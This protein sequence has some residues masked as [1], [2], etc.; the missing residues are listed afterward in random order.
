MSTVKPEMVRVWAVNADSADILDPDLDTP[1][2]GKEDAGPGKV[3]KG[4]DAD[5]V[6]PQ[7]WFN[8]EQNRQG[9]F[10]NH[11]NIEGIPVWDEN[12]KYVENSY[13]KDPTDGRIYRSL[14]GTEL[15]PN[16]GNQPS[17]NLDKWKKQIETELEVVVTPTNTAPPGGSEVVTLTPLLESSAFRTIINVPHGASEYR[18]ARDSAM[19]DLVA[20]SGAL[21]AVEQ[22]LVTPALAA[23]DDYFWDVRYQNLDGTW[24][25]RSTST[26]FNIPES[27]VQVP[28]NLL[29]T[30]LD[31]SQTDTVILNSDAF[32]STP[33]SV[34][35][36]SQWQITT[37][38][39]FVTI[40]FDSGEDLI[41]LLSFTQAG[42]ELNL[43]TYYWRVRYKSDTLGWSSFSAPFSF[44]TVNEAVQK[45]TNLTPTNGTT[46]VGSSVQLTGDSFTSIPGGAQVHT[47]SQWQ[48]G[49]SDFSVIYFDSGTDAVNL[50]TI[51]A[52]GYPEGTTTAYW[53]VR[54]QGDITGFSEWSTPFTF[55]TVAVF[56]DWLNWDGLSDGVFV[57]VAGQASISSSKRPV[58]VCDIG[59]GKQLVCYQLNGSTS[60]SATVMTTTG[61]VTVTGGSDSAV[62]ADVDEVNCVGI[63]TDRAVVMTKDDTSDDLR[64]A[65]IDITG[66][67]P[68][69]GADVIAASGAGGAS[70]S[71]SSIVKLDSG[72][73]AL[74]YRE[75]GGDL[76]CNVID[77]SGATPVAQTPDVFV[78]THGLTSQ[79]A[80]LLEADKIVCLARNTTTDTLLTIV[81]NF[82]GNTTTFAA[83]SNV[84]STS[85]PGS[86]DMRIARTGPS[87]FAY[88]AQDGGSMEITKA[89]Y[90]GG[91]VITTGDVA[92]TTAGA[93]DAGQIQLLSPVD[94]QLLVLTGQINPSD[95]AFV[96][97]IDPVTPVFKTTVNYGQSEMDWGQSVAMA[98]IDDTRVALVLNANNTGTLKMK[99]LNG[100]P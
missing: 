35:T 72:R 54:Y 76:I 47:A 18:V 16:V 19:T 46:E 67:T 94:D 44:T 39:N 91:D 83:S 75:V 5:N 59:G 32:L 52:T 38:V 92:S 30:D 87:A 2:P 81:C 84:K 13:S 82:S 40:D 43:T 33:P 97:P 56:A 55:V 36:A 28:T 15:D 60:V 79:S 7:T 26:G 6:P 20:L 49:N 73:V 48:V 42:I 70:T 17:L 29:P 99:I 63:D 1:G 86:R 89:T 34:H 23:G 45:P 37:D 50:E 62:F 3:E 69:I 53:R 71:N 57:S 78:G 51:S 61:L 93:D 74:F 85:L 98:V 64:V 96:T 24:S 4:W 10:N 68:S 58:D 77:V 21:G 41:N 11:V 8:W 80:V 12:S 66:T 14:S 95:Q 90:D 65:I 31:T 9:T 25:E 100:E 27:A 22:W 88:C